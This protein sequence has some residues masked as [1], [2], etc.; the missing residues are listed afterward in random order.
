MFSL[1]TPPP[2][3]LRVITPIAWVI[4]VVVNSFV[5]AADVSRT[6]ADYPTPITPAGWAFSIWSIIFLLQLGGS[7]Y[8]ALPYQYAVGSWKT[9]VVNITVRGWILGWICETLWQYF[10]NRA[11]NIGFIISMVLIIAAAAIFQ[12]ILFSIW[13]LGKDHMEQFKNSEGILCFLFF[14]LGTSLN[15]AWLT[16]A[17]SINVVVLF[18]NFGAA[19]QTLIAVSILLAVLVTLLGMFWAYYRYEVPYVLVLVWAFYGIYSASFTDTIRTSVLACI[20]VLIVF[21]VV[22]ILVK[23]LVFKKRAKKENLLLA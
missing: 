18:L 12:G 17:S 15:A 9:K 19:N 21:T 1:D 20:I 13:S 8:T 5:F 22:A 14:F 3:W 6:S 4:L 11:D 23:E 7:I 16:P 2:I 10:F